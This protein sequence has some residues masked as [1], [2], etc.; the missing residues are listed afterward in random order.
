MYVI[1]LPTFGWF[2]MVFIGKIYKIP[3]G[4]QPGSP[5]VWVVGPSPPQDLRCRSE[6]SGLLMDDHDVLSPR[7]TVN[8]L[9]HGICGFSAFFLGWR[10]SKEPQTKPR[11]AAMKTT[12]VLSSK[13]VNVWCLRE[14]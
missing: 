9:I 1:Y 12:H 7:K 11:W 4:M 10:K 8:V 6:G 3:M 13:G 5:I 2:L 14:S